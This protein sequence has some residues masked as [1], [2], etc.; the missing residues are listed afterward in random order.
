MVGSEETSVLE[1]VAMVAEASSVELTTDATLEKKEAV[2]MVV[3][4]TFEE[5]VSMVV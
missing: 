3:P 5:V 2:S 4:I 1:A